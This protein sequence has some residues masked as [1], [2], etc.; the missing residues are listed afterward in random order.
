ML[1]GNNYNKEIGPSPIFFD[2]TDSHTNA[3]ASRVSLYKSYEER[4]CVR[5]ILNN[6]LNVFKLFNGGR[7]QASRLT[8][9]KLLC[10][11]YEEHQ[12]KLEATASW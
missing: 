3:R 6:G 5:L 7:N 9:H 11:D 10:Y 2:I 4:H 12:A 8:N 1:R